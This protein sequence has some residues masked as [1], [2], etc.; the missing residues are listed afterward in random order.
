MTLARMDAAGGRAGADRGRLAEI[1]PDVTRNGVKAKG[2]P[3][4]PEASLRAVAAQIRGVLPCEGI[5]IDLV[6]GDRFHT[7]YVEGALQPQNTS[8][9]SRELDEARGAGGS[10]LCIP[11]FRGA[12]LI[13]TATLQLPE[14]RRFSGKRVRTMAAVAA[15]LAEILAE[16][17]PA[18]VLPLEGGDS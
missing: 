16:V 17:Q 2:R 13:G 10:D 18:S 12:R 4:Q 8:D 5:R 1:V 14:G 11:L 7:V 6:E 15:L 9:P 3:G